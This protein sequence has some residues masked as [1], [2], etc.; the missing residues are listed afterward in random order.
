MPVRSKE[1]E[2]G[3][4][5][6][7]HRGKNVSMISAVALRGVIASANIYGACDQP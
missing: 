7:I 6:L 1:E 3:E 5:D 4:F 2:P